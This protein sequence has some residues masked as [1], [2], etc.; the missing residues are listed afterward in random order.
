MSL[1]H[2]RDA[3]RYKLTHDTHQL[4]DAKQMK[5]LVHIF[6]IFKQGLLDETYDFMSN[7]TSNVALSVRMV[8][9]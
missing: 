3:P 4:R 6:C 9:S 7:S 8:S 2:R 5:S 1:L